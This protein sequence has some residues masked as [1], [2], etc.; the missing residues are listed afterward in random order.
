[1]RANELKSER[2]CFPLKQN[3]KVGKFFIFSDEFN[4]TRTNVT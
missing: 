1:M 3:L 4:L 2:N